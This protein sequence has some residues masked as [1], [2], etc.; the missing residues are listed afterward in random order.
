MNGKRQLDLELM[1]I[2]A[3]FFVIFNHTGG[4]GFLLFTLYEDTTLSYWVFLSVSVF[5]RFS[6]PLFF[7]ISGAVLLNREGET[8]KDLWLHRVSKMMLILLFWSFVYYLRKILLVSQKFDLYVFASV[9][10]YDNWNASFWYLYAYIPFLMTLPLL[11]KFVKG[12]SDRDFVYMGALFFVFS[13]LLP[14]A[15]YLLWRG[16]Y[17][18]NSHFRP[19]WICSNIL[20]YPCLGYFLRFRLKDYWNMKRLAVLWGINIITILVTCYLIYLEINTTGAYA[21]TYFDTFVAVNCVAVFATFQYL[22]QRVNFG[23]KA[24]KV[25]ISLGSCTF[26]I[27]LLH[28][29]F[30]YQMPEFARILDVLR[31]QLHLNNMVS[32]FLYCACIFLSG[33]L[34]TLLLKRIPLL[35]KMV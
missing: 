30:V 22:G 11:R 2:L 6:V 25:I 19:S 13:S 12:M 33:Y 15:Q 14:M 1:R 35:R 28:C 18:L 4:A 31:G 7:M 21:E 16:A 24:A 10:C 3:A 5:C 34:I 29:L 32:A 17:S 26:G 9:L 23:E 8:L 27:Y 20:F